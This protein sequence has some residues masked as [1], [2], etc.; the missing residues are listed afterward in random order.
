MPFTR[1]QRQGYRHVAQS[2]LRY[3]ADKIYDKYRYKQRHDLYLQ[4]KKSLRVDDVS[5]QEN[6]MGEDQPQGFKVQNLNINSGNRPLK[7]MLKGKIHY[8]DT[9]H[10]SNTWGTGTT[11]YALGPC[12]GT[13]DQWLYSTASTTTN[14]TE[15]S[16]P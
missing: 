5:A 11:H 4:Y 12:I 15:N 6:K 9:F 3:F 16:Y 1:S 7:R 8:R 13:R 2:Q 10:S 14:R